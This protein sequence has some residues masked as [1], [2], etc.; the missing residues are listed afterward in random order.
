MRRLTSEFVTVADEVWRLQ[1]GSD[2][3]S[4]FFQSM[5]NQGHYRGKGGTRQGI[6]VLSAN[7]DFLASCN[8][9]NP[10]RVVAVLRDGLEKWRAL[11]VDEQRLGDPQRV[12]SIGRSESF[13][14]EDGLVLTQVIRDL[15]NPP[16]VEAVR[17]ARLNH[18]HAWFSAEEAARF[19]P[20][21]LEVGAR[22]ELPRL[23]F[24]R[25][26]RFHLVDNVLGQ[27]IPFAPV[28]VSGAMQITVEGIE[29]DRVEI[30]LAG[31]AA[32]TNL[33]DWQ[34]GANEWAPKDGRQHPHG[35]SAHLVGRA[36]YDT[37]GQRFVDFTLFGKGWRWGRTRFNGRRSEQDASPIGW[38]FELQR[39]SRSAADKIPPAFIGI[40][41]APWLRR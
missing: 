24:E 29:G 10:D 28:E 32:G 22:H 16:V 21:E 40:Y 36:T 15:A 25:F 5:A 4:R 3:E 37:A 20:A 33:G 11:P 27:T 14:P 17:G 30:S 39:G 26:A 41:G 18:D 7:G 9:L 34:M 19:L 12:R 8:N 31:E 38:L 13:Y 23:L 35:V 1:R 2:P 6:Y